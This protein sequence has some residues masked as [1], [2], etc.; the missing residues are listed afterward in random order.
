[1]NKIF[2]FAILLVW[3]N[4]HRRKYISFFPA[5]APVIYVGRVH[6]RICFPFYDEILPTLRFRLLPFQAELA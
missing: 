6:F 1:M 3:E 5:L 4:S 2:K